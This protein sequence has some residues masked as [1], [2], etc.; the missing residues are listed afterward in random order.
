MSDSKLVTI[1]STPT[2]HYETTVGGRTVVKPTVD[3][4]IAELKPEGASVRID[5]YFGTAPAVDRDAEDAEDIAAAEAALS[6]AERDGFI[7]WEQVKA[8]LGY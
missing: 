6:E 5:L 3:E 7:P 4:L 2:G 8:E 1:I